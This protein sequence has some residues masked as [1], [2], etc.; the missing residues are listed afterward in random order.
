MK[1]AHQE[2]PTIELSTLSDVTGGGWIGTAWKGAK[3]AFK[4]VKPYAEHAAPFATI[5][6]KA[7]SIWNRAHDDDQR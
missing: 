2:L 4:V 7:R 3:A 5:A 6:Q 1:H